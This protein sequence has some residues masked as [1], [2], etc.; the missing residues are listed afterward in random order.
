MYKMPSSTLRIARPTNDL[1]ALVRFYTTA[2]GLTVLSSF[3]DHAGFDGVMLGHP[4]YSWHLEFTYQHGVTV[5]RAPSK[6]H[7]LVFYLKEKTEWE[8]A[9]KRVEDA[10]GVKVKSENPYWDVSGA[11]FEDPDGYRVVLQNAGWP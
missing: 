2:L 8:K 3:N 9:V 1:V 11:T 5:D 6:E 4:D 10:G 7:L